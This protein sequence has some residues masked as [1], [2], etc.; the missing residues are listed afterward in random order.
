MNA[1]VVLAMLLS[2]VA[3][4]MTQETKTTTCPTPER[5]CKCELTNDENGCPACLC[6]EE[7]PSTACHKV[8]CKVDPQDECSVVEENGCKI[9]KCTPHISSDTGLLS[10]SFKHA[11]RTPIST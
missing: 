1:A 4:G 10:T 5:S 8:R 9:C 6:H 2:G 11:T 7:V 3:G